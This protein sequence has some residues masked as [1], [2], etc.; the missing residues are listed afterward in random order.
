MFR[1]TGN[2]MSSELDVFYHEGAYEHVVSWDPQNLADF[3]PEIGP[4]E[5]RAL[6]PSGESSRYLIL[7]YNCGRGRV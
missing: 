3:C 4:T 5:H 1:G 7:C 2:E 6:R